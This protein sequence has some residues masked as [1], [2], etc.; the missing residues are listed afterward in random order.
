MGLTWCILSSIWT[1]TTAPK[2]DSP[3]PSHWWTCGTWEKSH[4][5]Q[6]GTFTCMSPELVSTFIS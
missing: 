5:H 3:R 6:P 2:T 1:V 4:R